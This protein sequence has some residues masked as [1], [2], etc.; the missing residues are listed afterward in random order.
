MFR[1]DQPARSGLALGYGAI[2]TGLIGEG[3]RRLRGAFHPA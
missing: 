3:L 2:D 1:V